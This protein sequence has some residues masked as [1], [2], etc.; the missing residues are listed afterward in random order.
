MGNAAFLE[1]I[2]IF[3]EVDNTATHIWIAVDGVIS[4]V[5][6]LQHTLN[7]DAKSVIY[8]RQRGASVVLLTGD[9][10]AATKPIAERLGINYKAGFKA[11]AKSRSH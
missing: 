1:D 7:P 2:E 5:F 4:A 3:P 6:S 9:T 10:D 8:L 11:A